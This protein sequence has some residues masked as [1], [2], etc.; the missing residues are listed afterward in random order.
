MSERQT[1]LPLKHKVLNRSRRVSLLLEATAL[2]YGLDTLR[3]GTLVFTAGNAQHRNAFGFQGTLSS[4]TSRA[5]VRAAEDRVTHT[6]LLHHAGVLIPRTRR[7]DYSDTDEA[8]EYSQ[9]FDHGA[10]IKPRSVEAGAVSR[11]AITTPEAALGSIESLKSVTGIHSAF[12]VEEF[13]PGTEY[14]FYVVGGIVVSV[15]TTRNRRWRKEVFRSGESGFGEINPE[16]IEMVLAAFHTFPK[17]PH[18]E[19]RL[20]SAGPR[21]RRG[22]S[23]VLAVNPQIH[24]LSSRQPARF[25]TWV[26]DRIVAHA[27]RAIIESSSPRTVIQ[28]KVE[29]HDLAAPEQFH[30]H[31]KAW[32]REIGISEATASNSPDVFNSLTGT[33]GQLAS[34]TG[35]AQAGYFADNSPLMIS[36]QHKELA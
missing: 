12:M 29:P 9:T 34:F 22:S 16:I 19:V 10:L 7:F 30:Q 28:A 32:T 2:A 25:A 27:G 24:L 4:E 26:A 23:T 11:K 35:L 3:T 1:R 8:V 33:P 18:G 20:V 36:T 21:L 17:M 14:I 15:V 6:A 31:A 5:S 13:I